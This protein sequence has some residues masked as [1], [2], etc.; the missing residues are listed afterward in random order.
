VRPRRLAEA[1]PRSLLVL[2]VTAT[3]HFTGPSC[4]SEIRGRTS[5]C[6]GASNGVARRPR[7]GV[8]RRRLRGSKEQSVT[9][10]TCLYSAGSSSSA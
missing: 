10:M 1:V 2:S 7:P 3:V 6:S 8:T 5:T 4:A 9:E